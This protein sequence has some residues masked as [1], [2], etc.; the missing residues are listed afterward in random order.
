[1]GNNNN[2]NNNINLHPDQLIEVNPHIDDENENDNDNEGNEGKIKSIISVKN[3]FY[4][5]KETISLEKDA[6]KNIY[7]IKFIF[8]LILYN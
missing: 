2:R 6:I 5:L 3:P 4:L 8:N 7:Y 1:M